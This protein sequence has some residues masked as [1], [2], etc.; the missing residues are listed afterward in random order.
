MIV[1]DEE[2]TLERVLKCASKFADE[3]IVVDTGSID[4]SIEIARKF[5]P[6]VYN[7]TWCNNFSKARNFSIDKASKDYFMWLD[8]DDYIDDENIEKIIELKKSQDNV[9]FYM[10]KYV[11]GHPNPT[12]EFF[13]ERLIKNNSRHYFDGA[14]HEAITP[15]GN[16]KYL[17][18]KIEHRKEKVIIQHEI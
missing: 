18:I 7:F 11:I 9:D 6:F 3:I 10:F 2:L 15:K 17:D 16:I 14:V 13:R 8:A 5:T 4:H 1:K 12:F